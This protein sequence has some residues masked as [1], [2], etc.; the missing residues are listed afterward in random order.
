MKDKMP[1]HITE[2]PHENPDDLIEVMEEIAKGLHPM[3]LEVLW[4]KETKEWEKK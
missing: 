2:G 3:V 4:D 1:D